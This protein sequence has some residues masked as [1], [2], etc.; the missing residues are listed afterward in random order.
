MESKSESSF[1]RMVWAQAIE[2]FVSWAQTVLVVRLLGVVGLVA[3]GVLALDAAKLWR[4]SSQ[5]NFW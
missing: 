1:H 3:G 2:D 5:E 4:E